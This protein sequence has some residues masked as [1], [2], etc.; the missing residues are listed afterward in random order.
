MWRKDVC[1]CEIAIGTVMSLYGYITA[2]PLKDAIRVVTRTSE[3]ILFVL[4]K[5]ADDAGGF[6]WNVESLRQFF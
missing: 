3:L 1:V 4:G 5:T 6:T 2:S